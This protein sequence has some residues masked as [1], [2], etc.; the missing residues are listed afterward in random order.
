MPLPVTDPVLIFA[1][2]MVII[3][4]APWLMSR[5]RVPGLV[6]MILAGA[7]VGPSVLGLL[8]RDATFE[9]L[10]TVGLLYLMF[11]AGVSIDLAQFSKMKGRSVA[12]GTVSYA[13]PAALA[14]GVAIYLLG[15]D[16]PSAI[17]LGSIVGSHTLLAYPI[18]DRL[19][20]TENKGIITAMGATM[21]TDILSLVAL[22]VV[23][24]SVG[25]D[26]SAG[27][28]MRFGGLV[29]V[30]A[31]AVVFLLPRAGRWFLRNVKLG[32]AV[33]FS[34]LMAALFL[35]AWLAGVVGLAPIIG[36]FLAGLMMNQFVP[37]QSPLMTR[38][39]FVGDALLIPFFLVSVGMLID[40]RVLFSSFSLWGMALVFTALVVV[41]KGGAAKL[42]QL[43][44]KQSPEEGWAV[45][46]LTIPQAAAT[47]AVTLVGFE[48][49]LFAEPIVNAV[50]VMILLT[51]ILGPS[52]VERFGREV[53]LQDR[54]RPYEPGE[55]PQRI[56][57][58][59]ANPETA[60]ALM[61]V[62]LAIR[63]AN[64]DQPVYPL[65]V[66][67]AG[68]EEA[69]A[70]AASEKLLAHAVVHAAAADVPVSPATRVDHNAAR[71][72]VRAVREQ[73]I[74]TVI[75]GWNGETSA[76]AMVFG[77]VLDQFLEESQ[78]MVFVSRLVHPLASQ[79]RVLL[80]VPPY[81]EREPGFGKALAA[82]KTL[83]ARAGMGLRVLVP[84][85]AVD[86]LRS[87]IERTD[88]EAAFR[89]HPLDAWADLVPELDNTVREG[90]LLCLISVRRGTV[91]WRPGLLRLPRLLASRFSN[92]DS[93]T[94][95]L[96][97]EETEHLAAAAATAPPADADGRLPD[98]HAEHVTLN[99][100][101]DSLEG[102]LRQTLAPA[103]PNEP[104]RAA[105][106]A[107][108]LAAQRQDYAP[109]LAPGLVLYPLHT[110]AV[111]ASQLLV[112]V[113]CE[114]VTLPKTSRP[115][116]VV[117]VLLAP[118][119][120]EPAGYLRQLSLTAHLAHR[121]GVVERL[122]EADS[123]QEVR[124]V[125]L[126]E[127]REPAHDAGDGSAAEGGAIDRIV[128]PPVP[129]SPVAAVAPKAGDAEG[130]PPVPAREAR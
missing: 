96:S 85:D 9:L 35:T 62:A 70:V 60:P 68:P 90:D 119:S 117:L 18:A 2:T 116:R 110:E 29:A 105:E 118:L 67:R 73:R 16:L 69:A 121:E 56:L 4:A 113:A 86:D 41:G 80:L 74:S 58:P 94:V 64:A 79:R 50:V 89:M 81:A 125:L 6:G 112:G 124:E 25:G 38:I 11:V 5:I 99:L 13:I 102:I 51:S 39:K 95:Y 32:A 84:A 48:V 128:E 55:A 14:L 44:F 3:L 108:Q 87:R 97:E 107:E 59:L 65:S 114:E 127:V 123:P 45:A 36:A 23:V 91:T 93:I 106:L 17:L 30:W 43:V 33:D 26:T 72:I 47:L 130:R 1:I 126:G 52:L 34:F 71:G 31:A 109:E 115:A 122:T 77:S 78:A 101:A 53:A 100:H 61:D 10:G 103:F 111:E 46:G 63:D 88:P 66:V 24:A 57:V 120:L 76:R 83:A 21:V 92:H 37:V 28:W 19:G 98:L 75:I 82:V 22:A 129:A 27:F 40:V 7:V 15:W 49:G 20:I 104:E 42:M 12:F 8:E 54:D